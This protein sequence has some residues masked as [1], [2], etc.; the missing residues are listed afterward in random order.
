VGG[1]GGL[2]A[3]K[4]VRLRCQP[5]GNSAWQGKLYISPALNGPTRN[6]CTHIEGGGGGG[7]ACNGGGSSHRGGGGLADGAVGG[8]VD[9]SHGVR[10]DVQGQ[11]LLLDVLHVQVHAGHVVVVL[12]HLQGES[13]VDLVG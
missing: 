9:Q 6:I 10:E 12:V 11:V 8:Q 3:E 13:A 1:G 4:L 7:V 2:L 5:P